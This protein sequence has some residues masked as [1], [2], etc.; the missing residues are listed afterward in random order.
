MPGGPWARDWPAELGAPG[1][2]RKE[3]PVQGSQ[4]KAR[5]A[6][7]RRT[8]QSNHKRWS[9]EGRALAGYSLGDPVQF[10]R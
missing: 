3:N 7:A 9:W 6:A 4:T 1:L 2:G 5:Q 8:E 10:T